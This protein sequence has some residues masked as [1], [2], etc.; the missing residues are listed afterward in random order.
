MRTASEFFY[1]NHDHF[2]DANF[3]FQMSLLKQDYAYILTQ[4]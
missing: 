4:N 1:Y 2:K 3:T